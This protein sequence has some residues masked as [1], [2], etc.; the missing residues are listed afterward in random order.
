[1]DGANN[2][3]HD[4][5]ALLEII[6]RGVIQT[7]SEPE[8]VDFDTA[9]LRFTG[10]QPPRQVPRE[11]V[12]LIRAVYEEITRRP[13]DLLALK[14]EIYRLLSYLASPEGRTDDNCCTTDFFLCV[15]DDVDWH[16]LPER[17]RDVLADMAGALHDTVS[18]PEV[19]A[20]FD[21]TPE[22]LLARLAVV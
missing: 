20:N 15:S 2:R 14:F 18:S 16:H 21:S 6:E 1:M 5:L 17:F 3:L 7:M 4:I 11:L 10:D 19:A 12:A 22:Q 13:S 9:W 8:I